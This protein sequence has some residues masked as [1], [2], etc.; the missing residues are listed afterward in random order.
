MLG[1]VIDWDE[2]A[3]R[4]TYDVIADAYADFFRSTEPEQHIELAMIEH[5]R[6]HSCPTRGFWM[7]D[8]VPAG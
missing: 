5:S 6:P 2:E 7:L 3:T 1:N 4:A 8:V